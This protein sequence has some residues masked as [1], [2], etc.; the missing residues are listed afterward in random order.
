[1]VLSGKVKEVTC[2]LSDSLLDKLSSLKCLAVQI[3]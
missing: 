1:M 2:S 3:C